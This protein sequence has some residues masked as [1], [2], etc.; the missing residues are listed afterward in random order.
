M[1][2]VFCFLVLLATIAVVL[3]IRNQRLEAIQRRQ[4]RLDGAQ[5]RIKKLKQEIEQSNQQ[6]EQLKF[7]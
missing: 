3:Y 4:R 5:M 7:L 2:A 1:I 6:M